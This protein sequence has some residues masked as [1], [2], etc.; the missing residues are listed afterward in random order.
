MQIAELKKLKSGTD[1]RGVAVEGNLPVNL[2]NEAVELT[3]KAFIKWLSLKYGKQS[4]NIAIGNDSR[5]SAGRIVKCA[6]EAIKSSGCNAVYTGLSS[7][8]SMFILLK[9]EGWSAD[10]SIMVT[11]SHMPYDRNGLKFF[12]PEGGLDGKDIDEIL[13][14]AV[15]GEF[16]CGKG[17]Y[18]EKSFMDEYSQILVTTVE[19]ACG[20]LPLQGK[21]IIVDAGNGAGGFF[22]EKVLKPLGAN[23]DGSQFLEP[24]GNFPNHIPNPEDRDA[25]ESISRAVVKEKANLGII[26]DTDVDRAGCVDNLGGEINRNALIALISAILLKDK[27]GT[28]VTDSVTSDG[29][30]EF[31]EGLGGKHVRFKRGYKNVIDK[32]KEL[33]ASGE[34][35]PLA[36]ETSGHAAFKENY[37]LDDG[38]YL[39]TKVLIS[40]AL[41]AKE[42]KSL[43]SLISSLKR[44]VEENEVRITFNSS[45]KDFKSEGAGVIEDLK[46]IA[47]KRDDMILSPVNYEGVRINFKESGGGWLLVRMSVHDPVMPI[48]FESNYV[49]GNKVF[50]KKLL[51]I[52]EAYPFLEITNLKKFTV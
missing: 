37:Y 28:I 48:N 4:F 31:I 14:L 23:T 12:T 30:T 20:K 8:P 11:A 52:L 29:L 13:A 33:N 15:K 19:R 21:K 36:I 22:A 44:P 9:T 49:G 43:T 34:Y 25:I 35:S 16:L 51:E 5:I 41:Q 45:S 6:V 46:R 50:A 40:L 47:T 38:A 24:D 26:F 17:S 42:G 2:T 27:S 1:V 32:C 10:A 18:S 3:V 7:T 39:I